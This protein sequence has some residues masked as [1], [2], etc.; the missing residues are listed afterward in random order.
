MSKVP[1]HE[2]ARAATL[3]SKLR[4][5]GVSPFELAARYV[6]KPP[7]HPSL[8]FEMVPGPPSYADFPEELIAIYALEVI[9]QQVQDDERNQRVAIGNVRVVMRAVYEKADDFTAADASAL[10]DYVGIT[11]WMHVWPFLRSEIHSLTTK[12]G[13]PPLLLP[14]L[15]AGQLAHIPVTR[16]PGMPE[17]SEAPV[18]TAEAASPKA[19]PPKAPKPARAAPKP[20]APRKRA[21][22]PSD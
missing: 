11:G 2:V 17:P 4:F 7:E 20:R 12:L 15:L 5:S 3:N 14:V 13:F 18:G 10:A 19:L 9:V 22:K 21:P 8:A 1:L 6:G 16:L